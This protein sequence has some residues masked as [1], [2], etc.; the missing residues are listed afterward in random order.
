MVIL[1]KTHSNGDIVL[2]V[3]IFCKQERLTMIGLGHPPS[4]QDPQHKILLA[5]KTCWENGGAI[6]LVGEVNQ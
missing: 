4:P 5:C 2:K 3:D 1:A 6:D